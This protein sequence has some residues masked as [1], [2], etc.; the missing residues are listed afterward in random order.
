MKP[1]FYKQL[2]A[3][4]HSRHQHHSVEVNQDYSFA[5]IANSVPAGVSEFSLLAVEYPLV[6]IRQQDSL[7]PV[8]VLGLEPSQNLF[9]SDDGQWQG[10]YKPAYVRRYPFIAAKSG[11]DK[12][13]LCIDEAA[14][15]VNTEGEGA[16]LFNQQEPSDYLQQM[17][18]FV[19]A[20]E[21]ES[22]RNQQ[23]ADLLEKYE[24]LEPC[25][26]NYVP[27]EGQ[28]SSLSGFLVVSR[29]RLQKLAAPAISELHTSGALELIHQHLL[30]LQQFNQLAAL[31]SRPDTMEA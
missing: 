28:K 13:T 31:S 30:S 5:A 8:A 21:D 4:S 22:V 26:M 14:N 18:D 24:L 2:A 25:T 11:G 7:H 17:L 19:K 23:L 20:Y 27:E 10:N 15:V 12:L 16:Q 9:V 6:F 3:V 29:E 1:L